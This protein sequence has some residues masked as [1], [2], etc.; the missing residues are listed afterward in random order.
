MRIA[1]LG[2]ALVDAVSWPL[3]HYPSQSQPQVNTTHVRL[4]P[5]GGATNV[6]AVTARLGL[7]ARL[8][9]KVG[10]DFC[11]RFLCEEVA[12][13]GVDASTVYV[14]PIEPTPFTF[15]GI[16]SNG[17]RTFTHTPGCNRTFSLDEVDRDALLESDAL[18]MP[19]IFALPRID[20]QPAVEML[21]LA[22][23]RGIRTLIDET[24]GMG[25]SRPLFELMV[26]EADVLAPSFQDLSAIYPRVEARVLA[27]HLLRLGARAVVLK[28]GAAG[29]LVAENGHVHRV[30][31][32]S[33]NVIDATG[34]GDA[35]DAGLIVALLQGE[36]IE[37][38][39]EVATLV[40]AKSLQAV[41]AA[42]G[43]PSYS[44]IRD[45]NS[46]K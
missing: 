38:A 19:D 45:S 28:M 25:P 40:A 3:D 43:V 24:H 1:C 18:V 11:G 35:F 32:Q 6:A 31:A 9:A 14:D 21:A 37:S 41:G 44:A 22:R 17:E 4:Q 2:L 20:G 27:L 34:A 12:A 10:D 16:G 33:T 13:A 46:A 23:Q 15:V 30:V 8:F 5:G 26:K 39:A 42:A 7:T 29:C 36:T